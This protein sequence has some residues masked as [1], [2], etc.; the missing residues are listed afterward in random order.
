M[1]EVKQLSVTIDNRR[2]VDGVSFKVEENDIMMVMGPNGA[3]KT[4]MIK[5]MMGMIP[6]EGKAFYE[7]TEISNF[8]SRQ[9]AQRIGVLAQKHQPQFS[10]TVSEVVSLGRYAYQKG[11]FG[12]LNEEDLDKI[13]DAIRLTG[14]GDFR[15]QSI[16]TLSGG[17][18]QRVFLAQLFAQDPQI[19]ILDEPT[20]HLDLQYQIAIFDIIKKW[21]KKDKRAVL[22]VVHDLNM[23]YSYG[24]NALLMEDG[25]VYTQGTVETVLSRENL[26]AVY[27]VDVAAWMQNLLNHW[28]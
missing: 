24:T 22:A 20:N 1:L 28:S 5:A 16:L 4:T 17:E 2:I 27:K 14:I 8:S 23:V 6:H 3:G 26:K 18:L 9:L 7:N 11:I 21:V 19:L 13:E 12:G 15:N 25:R 10:H